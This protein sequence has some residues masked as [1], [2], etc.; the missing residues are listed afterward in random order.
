MKACAAVTATGLALVAAACTGGDDDEQAPRDR[1]PVQG[2]VPPTL[3][4]KTLAAD[5]HHVEVVPELV[6]GTP[7]VRDHD[8]AH[9]LRRSASRHE[10][11]DDR[12]RHAGRESTLQPRRGLALQTLTQSR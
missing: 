4:N 10:P 7:M 9:P 12:A 5:F 3:E 8:L 2:R 11:R 6:E 1:T